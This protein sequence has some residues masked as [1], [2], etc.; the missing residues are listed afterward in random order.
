MTSSVATPMEIPQ[1]VVNRAFLW[2]I[3]IIAGLAGILYGYDIG[4]IDAALLFAKEAFKLSETMQEFVVSAVLVGAMAGSIWGGMIADRIGRRGTLLWGAAIFMAGSIFAMLAPDVYS[5]IAARAVL[6]ISIGFTS[7]TAPVFLSES[8]P[9]QSRGSLIGLYQLNL[10]LG[11]ALSNL[12][13]YLLADA[14][15]W[16]AMLGVGAAP[17]LVLLL[18]VFTLPESPRW[19]CAGP[20]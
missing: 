17:G 15:A 8:A 10:T 12:V 11:I 16:R 14:H 1:A 4:I 5:L 6:G 2:R 9:P 3:S 18:L 19:L 20:I 7:V 13:G